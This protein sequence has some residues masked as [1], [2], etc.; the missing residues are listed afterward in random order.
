VELDVL[1]RECRLGSQRPQ[2][3]EFVVRDRPSAQS[4]RDHTMSA[5]ARFE[6]TER[7]RRH[8]DRG[9]VGLAHST[10]RQRGS[11]RV[12]HDVLETDQRPLTSR[13]SERFMVAWSDADPSTARLH[14]IHRRLQREL[15]KRGPIEA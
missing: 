12:A 8:A 14:R 7:D 3:F 5:L 10:V 6:S 13:L 1:E 4:D 2:D 11:L 9:G 15:E